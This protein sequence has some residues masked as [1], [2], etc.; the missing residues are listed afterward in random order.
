[1]CPEFSRL[2]KLKSEISNPVHWQKNF[3][4]SLFLLPLI[5]LAIIR[6]RKCCIPVLNVINEK[7]RKIFHISSEFEPRWLYLYLYL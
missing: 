2:R 1:L 4:N 3:C 5:T 7:P 6:R